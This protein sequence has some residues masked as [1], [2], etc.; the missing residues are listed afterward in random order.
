MQT[1]LSVSPSHLLQKAGKPVRAIRAYPVKPKVDEAR[2][3]I[4]CIDRPS[5]YFQPGISGLHDAGTVNVAEER[6]PSV[7]TGRLGCLYD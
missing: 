7:C 4:R 3:F 6:K 1:A 2:Q 5:P